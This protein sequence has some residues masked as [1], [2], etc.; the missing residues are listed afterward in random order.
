MTDDDD[1]PP[2]GLPFGELLTWIAARL[3]R[4][5]TM[6]EVAAVRFAQQARRERRERRARHVTRYRWPQ[7]AGGDVPSAR[8]MVRGI[9][10]GPEMMPFWS[11]MALMVGTLPGFSAWDRTYDEWVTR[12]QV[13]FRMAEVVRSA[14]VDPVFAPSPRIEAAAVMAYAAWKLDPSAES[15]MPPEVDGVDRDRRLVAAVNTLSPEAVRRWARELQLATEDGER[16]RLLLD[17]R[18]L[19]AEALKNWPGARR[20]LSGPPQGLLA[21]PE[22]APAPEAAPTGDEGP[23]AGPRPPGGGG[24]R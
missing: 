17:L 9:L 16:R 1:L 11:A 19:G 10:A 18:R 24:R 5:P 22:P 2:E 3:G 4:R 7:R 23:P 14:P 21:E 15:V 6:E 8:H 12:P 20:F 13:V